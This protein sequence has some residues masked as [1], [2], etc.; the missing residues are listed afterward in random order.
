MV[1]SE[2]D[3]ECARSGVVS[4]GMESEDDEDAA[5]SIDEPELE[6]EVVREGGMESADRRSPSRGGGSGGNISEVSGEGVCV[7]RILRGRRPIVGRAFSFRCI[8]P[9]KT[10]KAAECSDDSECWGTSAIADGKGRK[11]NLE[12]DCRCKS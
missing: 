6:P 5:D 7:I 1:C 8:E 4:P 9:C 10:L 11:P 2:E 3:G 12:L